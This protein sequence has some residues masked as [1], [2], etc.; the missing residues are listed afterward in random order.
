MRENHEKCYCPAWKV[1]VWFDST[2]AL[3]E[4]HLFLSALVSVFPQLS[5]DGQQE[6]V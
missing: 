4:V 6:V 1:K 5:F 2:K 3:T